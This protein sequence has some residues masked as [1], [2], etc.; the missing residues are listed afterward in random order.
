MLWIVTI[1]NTVVPTR[2]LAAFQWLANSLV[3]LKITGTLESAPLGICVDNDET[4]I[5]NVQLNLVAAERNI[6]AVRYLLSG[7][8]AA[9]ATLDEL[10]KSDVEVYKKFN[11]EQLTAMLGTLQGEKTALQ[12]EK[13]ARLTI[14]S[15]ALALVQIQGNVLVPP[16]NDYIC[17][18]I[19]TRC[20]HLLLDCQK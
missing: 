14:Q 19:S 9:N 5:A 15:K 4:D 10:G 11:D 12:G 6:A 18:L 8:N 1:H 3:K 20:P 13:T 16:L 2:M 17:S 7:R